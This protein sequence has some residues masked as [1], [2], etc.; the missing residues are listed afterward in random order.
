MYLNDNSVTYFDSFDAEHIPKVI[1]KN[2]WQQKNN[3]KNLES[4]GFGF[5]LQYLQ[6]MYWF[7][8]Q[9]QKPERLYRRSNGTF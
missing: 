7:Y 5:K 2:Y 3:G 9:T 8:V 1:K 6:W 4:T